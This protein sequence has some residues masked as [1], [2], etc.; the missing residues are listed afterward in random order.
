MFWLSSS[1]FWDKLSLW[2]FKLFYILIRLIFFFFK[3]M[4]QAMSRLQNTC[5]VH[6]WRTWH[7]NMKT[8]AFRGCFVL[9][10]QKNMLLSKLILYPDIKPQIYGT[11]R[12]MIDKTIEFLIFVVHTFSS[13]EGLPVVLFMDTAILSPFL[14]GIML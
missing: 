5:L 11:C 12:L 3:L 10:L 9:F 2:G 14:Y 8:H 1:Y 4:V 6:V 7:F 13:L